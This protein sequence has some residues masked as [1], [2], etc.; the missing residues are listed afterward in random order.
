M[1]RS[2]LK[3]K[4]SLTQKTSFSKISKKQKLEMA[5]RSKLKGKL[6]EEY[7]ERCMTCGSAG[8]FRGISLSHIIPLSRGGKTT[9][10][11]CPLECYPC[12]EKYEKHPERR[13]K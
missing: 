7:G 6:I 9:R 11:N 12:H 8:D 10:A 2:P 13:P 3:R 5:A 4:K 1:K